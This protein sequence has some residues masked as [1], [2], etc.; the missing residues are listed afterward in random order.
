[1]RKE[2]NRASRK[3]QRTF[4]VL[5]RHDVRAPGAKR[6]RVSEMHYRSKLR[7]PDQYPS[8][9]YQRTAQRHLHGSRERRRVHEA[10]TYPSNGCQL[11]KNHQDGHRRR[12]VKVCA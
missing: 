1:M 9:E 11:D 2:G 8:R 3:L 10:V 5:D 6:I 4:G 7:I 12:D